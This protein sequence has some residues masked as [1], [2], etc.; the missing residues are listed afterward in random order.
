MISARK[1]ESFLNLVFGF[2]CWSLLQIRSSQEKETN[3]TRKVRWFHVTSVS[4]SQETS[5]TSKSFKVES[6]QWLRGL[7]SPLPLQDHKPELPEEKARLEAEGSE[8]R[9]VDEGSWRIYL[10][11]V[12]WKGGI[13]KFLRSPELRRWNVLEI[14]DLV[15]GCRFQF[16]WPDYV[17]RFWR[18]GLRLDLSCSYVVQSLFQYSHF[19]IGTH[20]FHTHSRPRDTRLEFPGC[21]SI[22]SSWCS[23]MISGMRLWPLTAFGTLG[24][25]HCV[26]TCSI[27]TTVL[28]CCD[29]NS[30]AYPCTSW[31]EPLTNFCQM[32]SDFGQ[33]YHLGAFPHPLTVKDFCIVAVAVERFIHYWDGST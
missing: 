13:W 27:T 31:V 32:L 1:T 33:K 8:V 21:Q 17:P 15:H 29:C 3:K 4:S 11:G 25:K 10:K 19:D 28:T 9:E 12:V 30:F 26:Q 23:Q 6:Y 22:T 2:W 14:L 20:W 18:Y 16:P 7:F 24:G 5:V